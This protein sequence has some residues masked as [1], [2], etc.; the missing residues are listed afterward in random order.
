MGQGEPGL[1]DGAETN[2]SDPGKVNPPLEDLRKALADLERSLVQASTEALPSDEPGL[3]AGSKLKRAIKRREFRLLRPI[4][5]RSDR[6]AAELARQARG[7]ADELAVALTRIEVLRSELERVTPGAIA[8]TSGNPEGVKDDDYYW[9]FEQQM[10][11]GGPLIESRL[12]QYESLAVGLIEEIGREGSPV[13]IDLGCGRGEFLRILGEW[14]WNALGVDSSPQ[15]IERCRQE[16]LRATMGDVMDF[17]TSYRGEPPAAVSGI[18]LIEH[19]PKSEWVEFLRST[20]EVLRPG[21]AI[22]LET[23]NAQ[24]PRALSDSFF[25]DVS[26]TWPAHPETLRLMARHVGFDPVELHFVN[27]DESGHAMDF[28][29]WGKKPGAP[30]AGLAGAEP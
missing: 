13:W 19:L 24:N 21:G 1:T 15:A 29:I 4:S 26:H 30:P 28:E 9:A 7:L 10:R 18:Q 22:L 11:G 20:H 2:A 27:H 23:V 16:G 8:S 5:R 17:L 14:G 6:L 3:L 25:A 12:R